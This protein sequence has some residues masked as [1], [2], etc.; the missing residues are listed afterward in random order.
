M[1]PMTDLYSIKDGTGKIKNVLFN[2]QHKR[3]ATLDGGLVNMPRCLSIF[4]RADVQ[5]G[6]AMA[7]FNAVAT[8]HG[9]GSLVAAFTITTAGV[10]LNALC[11][12]RNKRNTYE[13]AFGWDHAMLAIDKK[14]DRFTPPTSPQ[15]LFGS[16]RIGEVMQPYLKGLGLASL[17]FGNFL[18]KDFMTLTMTGAPGFG[19]LYFVF[20]GVLAAQLAD[21]ISMVRRFNNVSEKKWNI[22]EMPKKLERKQGESLFDMRPAIF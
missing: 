21:T 8:W 15:G 7:A 3:Y 6:L 13:Q 2:K 11:N 9:H 12:L 18:I 5:A 19:P 22:V 4:G 1:Y 14:P 10:G 17:L 16:E 20:S